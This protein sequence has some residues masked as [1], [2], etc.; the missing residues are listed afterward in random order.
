[1]LIVCDVYKEMQ[2]KIPE[3]TH[4][5]GTARVQ[6]VNQFENYDFYMLIKSYF[7]KSNI[8][9]VLN[10]SF[11]IKGELIVETPENAIKCFLRTGI[12]CLAIGN[13]FISKMENNN[14]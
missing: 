12:D 7:E 4:V 14:I 1:M 11:N 5:D 13:Y 9:V 6:I 2:E 10:T 8:P 3:V